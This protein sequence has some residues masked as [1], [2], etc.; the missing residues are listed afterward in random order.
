MKLFP[1]LFILCLFA[2]FA[3]AAEWPQYHGA[4]SDKKSQESLSSGAWL[5][6]SSSQLWKAE[7]PLGFSSFTVSG[8]LAYTLVGREDE[9]GLQREVC[10]ALD[11]NNGR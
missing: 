2:G 10:V 4:N 1:C 11:V 9:D 8:G 5:K 3:G 7:T 6:N